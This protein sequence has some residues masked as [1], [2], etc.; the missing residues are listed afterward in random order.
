M[1][2]GDHLFLVEKCPSAVEPMIPSISIPSGNMRTQ[3]EGT[4]QP[5]SLSGW[6]LTSCLGCE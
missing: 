5:R 3:W 4:R 6:D 2:K 1:K